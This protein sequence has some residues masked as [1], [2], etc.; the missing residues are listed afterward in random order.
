MLVAVFLAKDW[1][2]CKIKLSILFKITYKYGYIF[3]FNAAENQKNFK[4]Q[5]SCG[6]LI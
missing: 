4:M 5:E 2:M 1:V 6:H 3:G